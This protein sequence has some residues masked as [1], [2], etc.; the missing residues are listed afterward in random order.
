MQI[1]RVRHP[2]SPPSW[3]P[4]CPFCDGNPN[5]WRTRVDGLTELDPNSDAICAYLRSTLTTPGVFTISPGAIYIVG[6]DQPMVS[7][8]VK[9]A[10]EPFAKYIESIPIPDDAVPAAI[11]D[12]YLTVVQHMPDPADDRCWELW[13]AAKDATT[14][15]WSCTLGIQRM[16]IRGDNPGYSRNVRDAAGVVLEQPIWGVAGS[17]MS[18]TAGVVQIAEL[19]QGRID[20]A[21]QM[22]V[23]HARKGSWA[24]PAQWTDGVDIAVNSIPEG[25][26]F[27]FDPAVDLTTLG[28]TPGLLTIATAMQKYGAI[29][30]DQTGG[31]VAV[32]LEGD[33]EFKAQEGFTIYHDPEW[34]NFW[35]KPFPWQH[36]QLLPMDLRTTQDNT[37]F[38]EAD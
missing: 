31:T 34:T 6:P 12:H 9:E 27:R 14:G 33:S 8:A 29:V 32:A 4:V 16:H 24:F 10:W 35:L 30:L 1:V 26:H 20:H 22:N 17:R 3:R 19:Q 18:L 5:P 36:L 11:G 37:L 23:G 15:A 38:I 28:L 21:V 25:A 2:A 13:L 7:V